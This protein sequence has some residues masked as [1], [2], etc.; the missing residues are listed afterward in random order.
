MTSLADE[1]APVELAAVRGELTAALL[2]ALGR[3]AVE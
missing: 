3:V 2:A 1:G